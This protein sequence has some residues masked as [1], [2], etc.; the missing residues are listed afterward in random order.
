MEER[1]ESQK[2]CGTRL[3]KPDSQLIQCFTGD[4]PP[5]KKQARWAEQEEDTENSSAEEESGDELFV[6]EKSAK[7]KQV[8]KT[9][10]KSRKSEPVKRLER[11]DDVER[12]D[13]ELMGSQ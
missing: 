5:A 9:A 10:S 12:K 7:V 8:K 6:A 13:V 1:N 3:Q 11:S 4:L 2:V